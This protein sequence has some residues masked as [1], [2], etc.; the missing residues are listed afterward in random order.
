MDE[1]ISECE[2]EL[3]AVRRQVEESKHSWYKGDLWLL[4]DL[5]EISHALF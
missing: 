1:K 5:S 2:L 3:D 4:F